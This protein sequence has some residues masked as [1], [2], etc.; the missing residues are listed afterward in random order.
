MEALRL[1]RADH[2]IRRVAF[3]D[4]NP[5]SEADSI[6]A[7]LPESDQFPPPTPKPRFVYADDSEPNDAAFHEADFACGELYRCSRERHPELADAQRYF[8]SLRGRFQWVSE[9]PIYRTARFWCKRA[10]FTREHAR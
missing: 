7:S 4:I 1:A 8:D 5:T 3:L 2:G 10:Y 9:R 6:N